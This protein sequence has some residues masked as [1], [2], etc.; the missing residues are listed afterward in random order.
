MKFIFS[1]ILISY[2]FSLLIFP[3]K[4]RENDA[5]K[6][7]SPINQTKINIDKFLYHILNNYEFVSE[8]EVGTPRQ[9]VE[10]YLDFYDN[11]L[12]LLGHV[13]SINPYFYNL[14]STYKEIIKDDPNCNMKVTNSYTIKEEFHIKTGF[15]SK[16]NEFISSTDE[17]SHEFT[18]IFSKSLPKINIQPANYIYSSSNAVEIGILVNTKYHDE[19]G[20]YKPFLNEVKESGLIE[21]QIHFLYFFDKYKES[22]YDINKKETKYDGLVVFGKYP[23][24]LIPDKYEIKNLTWTNTFLETSEYSDYENI[25]WG[26]LFDQTYIEYENNKTENIEILRAVFDYNIEYILPPYQFYDIIDSFFGDLD[27]IC[28]EEKNTRNINRDGNIYHMK[29]CDYEKFGK[30]YLKTFPKL[31]FKINDLNE[32]FEFTY[33]D[34]FKPVYDNKYYLFLLFMRKNSY[35]DII[36]EPPLWT[37]GRMFLQKYQFVFDAP[38]KRVGYY[39]VTQVEPEET[40]DTDIETDEKTDEKTENPKKETDSDKTDEKDNDKGVSKDNKTFDIVYIILFSGIFI[41]IIVAAIIIC[42]K[43]V[44]NKDKR[45]KRTNELI[46]DAEYVEENNDDNHEKEEENRIN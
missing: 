3:F 32:T 15:Y 22:L 40:T 1:I 5:E 27:D 19:H 2:S 41:I 39:K 45:K 36:K 8:I 20:I 14:S 43:C 25:E 7:K 4:I 42:C 44:I 31:I 24:E 6:Y 28:F 33:K 11:Y 12:A 46:D 9:T 16:L 13:T 10:L 35:H 21:N 26:F 38:N 29:Y 30:D 17:I 37:L 23:H 18:I 34:L